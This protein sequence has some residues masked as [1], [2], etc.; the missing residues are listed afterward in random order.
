[1]SLSTP[2]R[3]DNPF[4][5]YGDLAPVRP[6]KR[7]V[8]SPM[9]LPRLVGQPK[10]SKKPLI[11]LLLVCLLAV[12]V[13]FPVLSR[14]LFVDQAVKVQEGRT[15]PLVFSHISSPFGPRWGRQ[16]QGIDFAAKMGT[17]VYAAS[18][19]I[20]SH[21][22]WETGY[23]KSVVVDHGNGVVTR[24]AH[25]SKVLAKPGDKIA[26]GGL[27]AKVGSTGHSTGPHL[28][29]EVLVNGVRKNPAWYYRFEPVVSTARA[30]GD[31]RVWVLMLINSTNR[32]KAIE[33]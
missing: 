17:P 7:T 16:H 13:L 2:E 11:S 33:K 27:I 6:L 30:E 14:A 4:K 12:G 1:M 10:A 21:S 3:R 20:V 15:L 8:S 28:H 24:Y 25:C 23:G 32:A 9:P 5:I 19:G 22:G 26:K 29:F 31:W 18:P